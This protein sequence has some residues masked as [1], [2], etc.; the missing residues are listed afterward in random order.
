MC[1][2][3]Y[4]R[5][6]N[7]SPNSSTNERLPVTTVEIGSVAVSNRSV[8]QQHQHLVSQNDFDMTLRDSAGL[9]IVDIHHSSPTKFTTSNGDVISFRYVLAVNEMLPNVSQKI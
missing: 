2:H 9:N 8:H 6:R 4:F 3:Y 1:I 5:K 7:H